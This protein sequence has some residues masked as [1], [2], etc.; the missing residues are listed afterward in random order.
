LYSR[1]RLPT[2]FAAPRVAL[3]FLYLWLLVAAASAVAQSE[4][5][6]DCRYAPPLS[7]IDKFNFRY[8]PEQDDFTQSL[9]ADK[10]V[11]QITFT[12]YNVFNMDDPREVNWLYRLANRLNAVTWES[13]VR[14]QLLVAEGQRFDPVML[15]ESERVLR[16]LDFLFDARM[17]ATRVCG[18]VVD[19]E[20]I[21][22]DIWTLTPTLSLSRSGGDNS[23]AFGVTDSN[24]LGSGKELGMLWEDDPDRSGQTFF[25]RDPAVL[26][27]RWHLQAV[28]TDNSDGYYRNLEVERPFYSVYE[29]WSAGAG[30]VQQKLE[31]AT[32][33]RGDEVT[34]FYQTIDRWNIF[35]AMAVD[36]GK[37]HR[38][39]R[40]GAGMHVELNEF[41]FSDS[42]IPP[43]AL[44]EDR[45]YVYPY[46]GFEST[47]YSYR[48][49]RNMNYIG[50]TEDFYTG[51]RYHWNL[52]WS[53]ESLGATRDHLAL[54]G[55]YENTLWNS[56][57]SM[58][59]IAGTADGYLGVDGGDFENLWLTFT[60]RYFYRQHHKWTFYTSARFD[61]ADGLT[62]DK[63]VLLGGDNGLR[64][65]ERN[66]QAGDRSFVVNI[67]ERYYSDL[68]PFRLFRVGAAVFMDIGRAWYYGEDNGANDGILADVGFGL[69]LNSSRANKRRVIHIDLAFP[70]ASGDN[71]ES[72]Q[73][74]F[75]VKEHF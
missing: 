3:Y 49:V 7:E 39:Q 60:S 70:L 54:Q 47:V 42:S 56:E 24:V 27:S 4:T 63:Q 26:D 65:Y 30:I 45:D 51:E 57:N 8:P 36:P 48:K 44:P 23:S 15:A 38:V 41:S 5:G 66:Y 20:V 53:A 37:E 71:V 22:R 16:E 68:H 12:R 72:L 19:V 55:A 14:S 6:D 33:F 50:R 73:L 67:E 11:G 40:W 2:H 59:H 21:T 62:Y 35:G 1:I 29:P 13:V 58:W 34:E 69:R 10:V 46:I 18:D 17:V 25:Y 52:G 61:Y 43:D 9:G 32:W 31:Q 64:G 75:R 74:L 28:Y